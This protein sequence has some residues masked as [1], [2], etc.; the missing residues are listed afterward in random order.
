ML[1]FL[2]VIPVPPLL[3]KGEKENASD[4]AAPAGIT[5]LPAM[6]GGPGRPQYGG[7]GTDACVSV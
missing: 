7:K 6:S 2:E 4:R 5:A 3:C 1:I